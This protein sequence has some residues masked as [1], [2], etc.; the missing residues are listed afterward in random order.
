M[1]VVTDSAVGVR[2][3]SD[4]YLDDGDTGEMRLLVASF[5]AN[6]DS[7]DGVLGLTVVMRVMEEGSTEVAGS[8]ID[9]ENILVDESS[10]S[11]DGVVSLVEGDRVG[12]LEI[13]TLF[14]L[15]VPGRE[16]GLIAVTDVSVG[17]R[18][19]S[20]VCLDD[21]VTE[22][23]RLRVVSVGAN[24]DSKDGVLGL[25]VVMRVMEEGSTEDAGSLIDGESILVDES[26]NSTDGVVDLVEGDRV[27][28][29]EIS[30]LVALDVG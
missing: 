25:T 8:L 18:E 19:T 10:N 17:V 3:T 12:T 20:D 15:D 1:V 21:G 14:V 28:T 6:E 4:V 27:G 30:T 7:K 2:E 23:M 29:L 16:V 26:S 9:G 11:T 5:R 22:G 13:S 24:E